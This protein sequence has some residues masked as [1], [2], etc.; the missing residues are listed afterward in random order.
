MHT[1]FELWQAAI[2]DPMLA[3]I[4]QGVYPRHRSPMVI[5]CLIYIHE[6]WSPCDYAATSYLNHN[7][8]LRFTSTRKRT[9]QTAL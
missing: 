4:M 2:E 7:L 5:S 6:H 8:T 3:P 9:K 1:T